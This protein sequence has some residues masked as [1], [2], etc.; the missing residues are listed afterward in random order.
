MLADCLQDAGVAISGVFDDNPALDCPFPFL[1]AYNPGLR[2]EESILLAVGDNRQRKK[3]AEIIAHKPASL[4][5]ASA[6][7]SRQA[8]LG[9]GSVVLHRAIIQTH[10][11]IGRYCI[12]N[13]GAIL[14]H[15]CRLNDFVHIAP[16]AILCGEVSI[17]AGSLIGAGAIVLPG[18]SVGRG[19]IV[20]AG[21][22]VTGSIAE[23]M[24][25][26]GNP[27]RPI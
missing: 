20:G 8:R 23:G 10:V 11:N 24:R 15:D 26:Y 18:I 13:S 3:L 6:Q 5:H 12:I 2:E 25:C 1:G 14:E 21:S 22:V 27:A 4:V 19:C 17:G 7:L 16:G 9:E